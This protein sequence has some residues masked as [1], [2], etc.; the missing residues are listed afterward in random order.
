MEFIG[1]RL[2][3]Q[4]DLGLGGVLFGG[5]LLEW[6]AEEAAV[7]A[8][9]LTGEARMVGHRYD[10]VVL[11]RPVRPGEILEFYGGGAQ[12]RTCG[13]GFGIEGR[14]GGV[15]VLTARCVYVAVDAEGGK[16]ALKPA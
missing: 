11:S 6:L 8:M 14:V 16:K 9:R 5:R 7:Y 10:E 15:P 2:C 3:K 13:V 12:F 4:C 1:S